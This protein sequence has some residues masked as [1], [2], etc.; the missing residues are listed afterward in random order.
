MSE[1]EKK[2]DAGSFDALP[3]ECEDVECRGPCGGGMRCGRAVA[4]RAR[5]ACVMNQG[6]TWMIRG[7]DDKFHR[8]P[9]GAACVRDGHVVASPAVPAGDY[10]E[11]MCEPDGGPVTRAIAAIWPDAGAWAAL[12]EAF[13]SRVWVAL[14]ELARGR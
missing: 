7:A 14:R 2:G 3:R 1:N 6:C 10:I 8:C 12:P 13:R 4:E 9:G 11:R 5:V